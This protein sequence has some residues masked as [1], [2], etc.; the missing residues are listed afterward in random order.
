MEYTEEHIR[1][2]STEHGISKEQIIEFIAEFKAYDTDG[3]GAITT[4][5]LGV[6]NKVRHY[7][8]HLQIYTNAIISLP[9]ACF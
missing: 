7:L 8:N 3:N 5:D 2:L 6:V 9:Q 1:K 4:I